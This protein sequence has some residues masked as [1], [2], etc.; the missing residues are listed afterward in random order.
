[1][2]WKLFVDTMCT[3]QEDVAEMNSQVQIL[4]AAIQD[5]HL[6]VLLDWQ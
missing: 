4:S 3:N 2:P 5:L 1:M 6:V